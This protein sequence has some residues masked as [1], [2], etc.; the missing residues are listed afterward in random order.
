M[1]AITGMAIP[2]A[3]KSVS[4]I[5][6]KME[7]RGGQ[8]TLV[9]TI[10]GCTVGLC[11]SQIQPEA[12]NSLVNKR[13]AEDW[14]NESHF[15][16]A[17]IKD[18]MLILTRDKLGISPLY[19]GY[20]VD[21]TLCFSSE[22]K[23][24][25]GVVKNVQELKPGS[26][27]KNGKI[28]KNFSVK[29]SKP[30]DGTPTLIAEHLRVLLENSVARRAKSGSPFGAWLSGGL[31]SSVLAALA[32]PYANEFHTFAAGFEGA[33]DLFFAKQVA[34]HIGSIH[35]EVIPTFRDIIAAIPDVIYHL[36]SFD[37]LLVRSSLMNFLVAKAASDYV[38]AVFSGEGG[39]ELFA[40]YSYLKKVSYLDLPNELNDIIARLHNTA[41][42]RVD[43]C[44]AAHGTI[45]YVGFL[46]EEIVD[47]A[48]QIPANLK[49]HRG[50]E[51][52]ILRQAVAD[53]LP[54]EIVTREKA[55][56]WEGAGVEA[57]IAD[58][59]EKKVSNEDFKRERILPNGESLNSKEELYYYRIFKDY[60]GK[61]DD[62]SWMGRTKG[63][64]KSILQ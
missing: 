29:K 44:A 60:Y 13:T 47:Y 49:I 62:I 56:F 45:A 14:V 52:W 26:T 7:H 63:S 31:D 36:E 37:A 57:L 1:A 59:V 64:P 9:K 28:K 53:L 51:K 50:I 61:L 41:L 55:K 2:N 46:G 20:T 58:Y 12:G 5:L 17:E 38:P 18:G 43:R 25:V 3:E 40:G 33:P 22:V 11:W 4:N 19:F 21:H 27:L 24:L 39:D 54:D 48:V 42:Q 6:K 23:G 34:K 35:H 32:R 15:A 30:M 10:D 8:N 16:K